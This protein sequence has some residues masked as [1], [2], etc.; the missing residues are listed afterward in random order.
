M[1]WFFTGKSSTTAKKFGLHVL[2]DFMG[3]PAFLIGQ[4]NV[5]SYPQYLNEYGQPVFAEATKHGGEF[6]VA[7]R[8]A[9]TLEGEWAGN[10]TVV[11]RFP[12]S[13]AALAFYESPDYAPLREARS[14]RL[15]D[16]GNIVFVEGFDPNPQPR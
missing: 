8:H 10:W 4:I 6:L 5:K 2:E 1:T 14:E 15:S 9:K 12:T 11:I 13:E 16:G 7:T 3:K